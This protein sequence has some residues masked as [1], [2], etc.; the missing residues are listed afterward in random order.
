MN[1]SL[2]LS[3]LPVD[4][5]TK[6]SV[7]LP[8]GMTIE[9]IAKV[10][11]SGA[12]AGVFAG[13]PATLALSTGAA[14][15]LREEEEKE[16][17]AA[18]SV[19][20]LSLLPRCRTCS[21]YPS[22]A[23]AIHARQE[24]QADAAASS[25][26][27]P[28]SSSSSTD[29]SV[30]V[31]RHRYTWT[32]AVCGESRNSADG[33]QDGDGSSDAWDRSPWFSSNELCLYDTESDAPPL[34]PL[35][36]NQNYDALHL[37][38]LDATTDSAVTLALSSALTAL[39]S[40][41]TA[42]A[43]ADPDAP[44]RRTGFGIL[45][46]SSVLSVVHLNPSTGIPSIE[47]I[48]LTGDAPMRLSEVTTLR[49]MLSPIDA[50]EESLTLLME[51]L[52]R[53][54]AVHSSHERALGTTLRQLVSLLQ[55][56]LAMVG[57]DTRVSLFLSG[58]PNV[59]PGTVPAPDFYRELA[60]DAAPLGIYFDLY[61]VPP[62]QLT[63]VSR[64]VAYGLSSI[65]FLA[66]LT[67]G[68]ALA[69]SPESLATLPQDVH[70]IIREPYASQC[71]LRIRAPSALRVVDAFGPLLRLEALSDDDD[72][73]YSSSVY[74]VAHC[75][76]HTCLTFPLVFAEPTG[77]LNTPTPT[78]QVTA[79]F[80]RGGAR[81]LRVTTL[82]TVTSASP[83]DLYSGASA[84]TALRL[85]THAACSTAWRVSAR[86]ARL[87]VQ[88]WLVVLLARYNETRGPGSGVP[89]MASAVDVSFRH[90][91][92]LRALPR[93][94]F[95]L[96]NS[97]ALGV[98]S[99]A[100]KG[101]RAEVLATDDAAVYR[102]IAWYKLAPRPLRRALYP[103]LCA[104]S[105]PDILISSDNFLSSAALQAS[106]SSARYYVVIGPEEVVVMRTKLGV[107][108]GVPW[109][110]PKA[111]RLARHVKEA[112][113]KAAA[114]LIHTTCSQGEPGDDVFFRYLIDDESANTPTAG[115]DDEAGE[116]KKGADAGSEAEWLIRGISFAQFSELLS[117]EVTALMHA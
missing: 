37:I 55:T 24:E 70:R 78:I 89:S 73:E 8:M 117:R 2:S 53:H 48:E 42:D 80:V 19:S 58:P 91:T 12:S 10:D 43:D 16:G 71:Y 99:V 38:V 94:A 15:R 115:T 4:E 63:S 61:C 44:A 20:A 28:W 45:M 90:F 52:P 101:K 64:T 54:A 100:S 106:S 66:T 49:S 109:P 108:D 21:A 40:T 46:F 86:E 33:L 79:S 30:S 87:L 113:A 67:G 65:R 98:A 5:E 32:C 102:Q 29:P 22:N 47:V 36:A 1:A 116:K 59:G 25:S 34:D 60:R 75:T 9:P 11:V 6:E 104:Y 50:V 17:S 74:L 57:A 97:A 35:L 85:L 31:L 72:N 82:P 107:A 92:K 114:T 95:A 111:C 88:D 27:W 62:S 68:T 83:A 93:L 77:L 39:L 13:H 7:G 96:A 41:L 18:P 112:R 51:Y 76:E 56:D 84:D 23:C 103:N 26:W 105:S 14:E 69:Y 81:Y 110:V 3:P